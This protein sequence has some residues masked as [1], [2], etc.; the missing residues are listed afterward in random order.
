MSGE[1]DYFSLRIVILILTILCYIGY[2]FVFFMYWF[3]KELRSFSFELVIWLCVSSCF[4][5]FSGF[6]WPD[7]SFHEYS[8]Y[9]TMCVIQSLIITI[10]ESSTLIITCIIGY[11]TY[12]NILNSRHLEQKKNSLRL[13]FLSLTTIVPLILGSL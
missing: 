5:S 8:N 4:Y 9:S 2:I 10:F 3:F 11:T 7:T 1:D 13:I 12:I 6:I